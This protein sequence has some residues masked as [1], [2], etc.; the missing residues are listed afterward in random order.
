MAYPPA[1][2]GGSGWS[3]PAIE[4]GVARINPATGNL[5]SAGSV[6]ALSEVAPGPQSAITAS[7]LV[8][9][10]ACE[11]LGFEVDAYSGG[12]Q[13]VSVYDALS[14]T[15]NPFAVFTVSGVGIYAWHSDRATAG[16]GTSAKRAL[17]TGCY[18]AVSGG[19]SRSI[20]PLVG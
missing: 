15:G 3:V 6:F 2:L 17:S 7:G 14:A 9:T 4:G 20:I 16:A 12:P 19:T 11:F 8:F 5:E 10:G 1:T 18:F 13:T